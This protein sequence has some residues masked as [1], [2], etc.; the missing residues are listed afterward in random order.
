MFRFFPENLPHEVG[1]VRSQDT[2]SSIDEFFGQGGQFT[3]AIG[4]ITVEL[5]KEVGLEVTPSVPC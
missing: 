4:R 5:T 1:Q 2:A 3:P